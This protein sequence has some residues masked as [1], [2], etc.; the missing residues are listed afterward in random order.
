MHKGNETIQCVVGATITV[1]SS[2]QFCVFAIE[3]KK[4]TLILGPINS[5]ERILRY[6]LPTDIDTV[7]IKAEPKIEWTIEWE[8]YNRSETLDN[9]PVEMPIGYEQ[10]ETLADQ[11]RRFIRDEVSAAREEDQGSFEDEDDFEDDDP[12]LTKY[13]MTDM[14]E[15]EEIDWDNEEE[16]IDVEQIVDEN[17]P[18]DTYKKVPGTLERESPLDEKKVDTND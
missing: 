16:A 6:K 3:N 17:P 1:R 4:R 5:N 8:Y 15:M 2:G 11:M 10:P 12:P 7:F 18:E 13:E 9:T 14:Q